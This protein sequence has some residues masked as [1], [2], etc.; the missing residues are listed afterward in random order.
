MATFSE[1]FE[2]VNLTSDVIVG[3]PAEDAPIGAVVP[4]RA[5]APKEEEEG[6][7]AA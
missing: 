3:F 4:D 7:L 6:A 1:R 2:D 5:A